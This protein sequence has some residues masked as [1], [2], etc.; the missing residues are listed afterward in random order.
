[1]KKI[2]KIAEIGQAHDGSLG[3]AHSFID[4]LKDTGVDAVKFQTH[5]A[6]AE[7]SSK[8]PFRVKF[9]YEDQTRFDYWKR[10][11]FTKDQWTGIKKHCEEVNLEFISS[12]FSNCAVSLLESLDVKRYKIGSGEVN[13][14]LLLEKVARTGK[15]VLLSSG[16]S[17]L[18]ELELAT[19]TIQKHHSNYSILQCTTKYPTKPTDWGLHNL[20]ILKDLFKVR[21]G[22]SDHSG[23]IYAPLFAAAMGA[24]II[25]FHVTYDKKMFGPDSKASLTVNQ[26]KILCE[27]LCQLESANGAQVQKNDLDFTHL[28]RIFEK[29]IAV[30]KDLEKGMVLTFADLEGKKPSGEG[31]P[32]SKWEEVIGKVLCRDVSKW[33]FLNWGDIDA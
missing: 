19:K 1:M 28:K 3:L 23:Q 33:E 9:S 30:N 22:F 14:L 29:S 26:T 18:E 10:M 25:E 32:A 24:E 27:G 7:S 8:E 6:E 12:P 11:E 16:M 4:A 31:I 13:N 21:V 17:S 5:I 15:E 20:K 2:L